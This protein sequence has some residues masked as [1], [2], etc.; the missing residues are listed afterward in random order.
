MDLN[1][2]FI[3]ISNLVWI[4]PVIRQYKNQ[5]FYFFLFLSVFDILTAIFR[6]IFGISSNITYVV[7][8]LFLVFALQEVNKL[9]KYLV[10]K[11]AF[12]LLIIVITLSINNRFFEIYVIGFFQFIIF[13]YILLHFF[14]NNIQK[15]TLTLFYVVL[16][17]FQVLNVFKFI[18]IVALNYTGYFYSTIT[19]VFQILTGLFFSFVR[20][21]TPKL[22]FNLVSKR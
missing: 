21:D 3:R 16:V 17:L 18:N 20:P 9:K 5:Y 7:Q 4:F 12:A 15:Q 8:V 22:S 2:I 6:N 1:I 10:Y 19:T 11:I 14:R 13:Y